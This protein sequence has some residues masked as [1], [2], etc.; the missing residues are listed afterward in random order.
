MNIIE[1]VNLQ[2]Q[3]FCFSVAH[4]ATITIEPDLEEDILSIYILG[5]VWQIK[6]PREKILDAYDEIAHYMNHD[7]KYL[8]INFSE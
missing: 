4:I 5:D 3:T 2:G 6:A 8:K 1:I 7:M